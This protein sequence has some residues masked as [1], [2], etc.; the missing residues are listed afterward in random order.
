MDKEAIT[1]VGSTNRSVTSLSIFSLILTRHSSSNDPN[2]A[3]KGHG[4]LEQA[5]L[6]NNISAKY[7]KCERRFFHRC[8]SKYI[9][10]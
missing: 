5:N 3:E 9:F 2:I 1:E 6:Q 8:P 4:Y 10:W 7:V